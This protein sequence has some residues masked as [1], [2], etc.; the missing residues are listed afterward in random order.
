MPVSILAC[1]ELSTSARG[2]PHALRLSPQVYGCHEIVT[3][4]SVRKQLGPVGHLGRRLDH[5]LDL[6]YKLLLQYAKRI[7]M[8]I[9]RRH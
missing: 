7:T 6:R 8:S 2:A 4:V 1:W 5:T 9:V 3:Q